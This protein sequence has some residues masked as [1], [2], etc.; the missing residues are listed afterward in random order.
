MQFALLLS[1]HY[2]GLSHDAT[3]KL[4]GILK[5]SRCL[6]S[7]SKVEQYTGVANLADPAIVAEIKTYISNDKKNAGRTST[8]ADW[9]LLNAPGKVTRPTLTAK[10]HDKW[11]IQ[12]DAAVLDGIWDEFLV[13]LD[14]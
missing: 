3:Q 7:R 13:S 6:L 14:T 11:T 12:V 5:T 8:A 10:P 4:S 1:R 2:G 9:I